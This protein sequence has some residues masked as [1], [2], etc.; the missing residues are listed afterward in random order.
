MCTLKGLLRQFSHGGFKDAFSSRA[1]RPFRAPSV[2]NPV[3]LDLSLWGNTMCCLPGT[4]TSNAAPPQSLRLQEVAESPAH[5]IQTV[6]NGHGRVLGLCVS[7]S[8]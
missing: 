8:S 4:V 5:I 6:N 7:I 3:Q 2:H 1:T